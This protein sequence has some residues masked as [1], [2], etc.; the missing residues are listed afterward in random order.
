MLQ[1]QK[2][3]EFTLDSHRTLLADFQSK[4]ARKS[5]QSTLL[6]A[7]LCNV[8]GGRYEVVDSHT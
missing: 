6:Q 4:L 7:T 2:N 8:I 5:L 1:T 3:G